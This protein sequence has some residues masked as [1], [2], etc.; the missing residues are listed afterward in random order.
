[1]KRLISLLAMSAVLLLP[2]PSAQARIVT[3]EEAATQ[4][5]TAVERA[6]I[7]AFLDRSG[8]RERLKALG[9]DGLM[10]KQR[11][12]ALSDQEVHAMAQ[13]LDSMPAGGNLSDYD[14]IVILLIAILVAIAV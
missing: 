2:L 8:V 6:R 14:L 11:V 12:A 3:T 10:A 4:D 13:K 7:Q 1:M 9:V 5:Q